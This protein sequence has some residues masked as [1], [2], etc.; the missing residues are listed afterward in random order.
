[1]TDRRTIV[2]VLLAS[3][4]AGSLFGLGTGTGAVAGESSCFEND[5]T[6]HGLMRGDVDG[7]GNRDAVWILAKRRNGRC[8]YFVKADLGDT[9]DRK[10]LHGSRFVARHHSRVMAMV[11]V[12]TVPGKEFGVVLEQGAST[13]F[14]GLFTIRA[15]TIRRMRVEGN[16]A[17]ADDLFPY[18][19]SIAFQF[20]VDC[21]RHRPPGQVISTEA[22][23][24]QDANRYKVK[25]R[26]FQ[27][28]GVDLQRT[29]EPTQRER[30]RPGRLHES[31]YEFRSSPFGSCAGRAPG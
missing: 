16:G 31:F 15:N 18:G 21:A 8:R 24:D 30:V 17:P 3:C 22:V 27:V 25:R 28:V 26:W 12:D 11:K 1:M 5:S 29:N 13:A 20:A 10:R 6:R 19:G 9:E 23:Y 2:R 7:D 4:L 14:A